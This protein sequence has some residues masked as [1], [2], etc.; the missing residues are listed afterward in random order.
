MI[1]VLVSSVETMLVVYTNSTGCKSVS[2][3][4]RRSCCTSG[5]SIVSSRS[6]VSISTL[7]VGVREV[8]DIVSMVWSIVTSYTSMSMVSI[9][10]SSV[11]TM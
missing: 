4:C 2:M 6:R 3:S 10:V 1:R 9:L 7:N 11:T 5:A 8:P